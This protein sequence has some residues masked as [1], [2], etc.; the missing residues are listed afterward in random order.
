MRRA[1]VGNR[2][3]AQLSLGREERREKVHGVNRLLH[4]TSCKPGNESGDVY[5]EIGTK[6][7]DEYVARTNLRYAQ[8]V[9]QRL[10][11]S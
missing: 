11:Q 5:V 2:S 9:S 10:S 6:A 1:Q 8:N 3:A 7:T 4:A